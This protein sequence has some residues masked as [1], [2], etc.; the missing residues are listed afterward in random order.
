MTTYTYHVPIVVK[1]YGDE[2]ENSLPTKKSICD[3]V[4]Q[5]LLLSSW[6]DFFPEDVDN[7]T[8][9]GARDRL[10]VNIF[11]SEP[12]SVISDEIHKVELQTWCDCGYF[13]C[14]KNIPGRYY[15]YSHDEIVV[16]LSDDK[17]PITSHT[18]RDAQ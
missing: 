13:D 18:K 7:V 6:R 17:L 12:Y 9:E 1:V 15:G 5:H 2:E 16:Y 11:D 3:F 4:L 8:I 10:K 14:G